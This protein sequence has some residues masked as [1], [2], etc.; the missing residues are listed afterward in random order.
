MFNNLVQTGVVVL[1]KLCDYLLFFPFMSSCVANQGIK[2]S[3]FINSLGHHQIHIQ[4]K[5]VPPILLCFRKIAGV[6][7]PSTAALVPPSRPTLA[8]RTSI[9]QPSSGRRKC[10]QTKT[11]CAATMLKSVTNELKKLG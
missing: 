6:R 10:N 2:N 11:S 5:L 9:R 8:A 4:S 7:T 1:N 3:L